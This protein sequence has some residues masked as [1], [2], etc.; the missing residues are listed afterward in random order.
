MRGAISAIV[1]ATFLILFQYVFTLDSTN[2][3]ISTF[4][5][6]IFGIM[7]GPVGAIGIGIGNFISDTFSPNF[8]LE[9]AAIKYVFGSLG[10]ALMAFLSYIMWHTIFLKA[11]E[12]PFAVNVKNI[13]RYIFIQLIVTVVTSLYL[14]LITSLSSWF[15]SAWDFFFMKTSKNL[16]AIT[17]NPTI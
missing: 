6:P 17:T 13:M 3:R 9:L 15:N 4:L 10:N 12:N 2:I 1:Y 7:W 11:H 5:A 14:T 16:L 8:H